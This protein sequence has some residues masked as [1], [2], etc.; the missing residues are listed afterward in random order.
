MV[1]KACRV[2]TLPLGLL[3]IL[4]GCGE[5]TSP[6]SPTPTSPTASQTFTLSGTITGLGAAQLEGATVETLDG[7]QA[8]ARAQTNAQ[9][10]Y[11]ITGLTGNVNVEAAESC[12]RPKRAGAAMTQ[13]QVLDFQLDPLPVGRPQQVSP[14]NGTVFNHFPRTTTL[15]WSAVPCAVSYVAEWQL[16]FPVA[17]RWNVEFPAIRNIETTSVTFNFVGAQPGRWRVWSIDRYGRESAKT[18]W[19]EFRYTV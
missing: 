11:E 14:R 18:G 19:W 2:L 7:D 10:M 5:S 8:G 6:T 3:F 16:F 12:H 9:G 13:N 17:R 4:S 15:V 1:V